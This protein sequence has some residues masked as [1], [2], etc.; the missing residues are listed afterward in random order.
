VS[1]VL[2]R[3]VFAW[4]ETT[5]LLAHFDFHKSEHFA[6]FSG[7]KEFSLHKSVPTKEKSSICKVPSAGHWWQL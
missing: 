7:E 6:L 1:Y 3:A 2:H 5:M 4:P